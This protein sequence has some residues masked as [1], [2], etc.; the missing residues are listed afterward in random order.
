MIAFIDTSTLIKKYVQELGSEEFDSLLNKINEIIV[1][2]IYFLEINSAIE[3][4]LRERY[5]TPPQANRIRQESLRDLH[6]FHQINWNNNLQNKAVALLH[7]HPLKTLDSIQLA[8]GC[9]S[10]CDLFVCSDKILYHIA[11]QELRKTLLI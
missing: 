5:I 10:S 8:S 3:R 2:P 1:A 4:K 9:L 7:K 11:Q 6:F